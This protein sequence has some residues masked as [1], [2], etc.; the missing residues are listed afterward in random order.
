ML[1]FIDKYFSSRAV[2]E[3]H[4]RHDGGS[5]E[6]GFYGYIRVKNNWRQEQEKREWREWREMNNMMFEPKVFVRREMNNMMFEPKVFV[7]HIRNTLC[8]RLDQKDETRMLSKVEN[9]SDLNN[10]HVET[11]SV[12]QTHAFVCISDA[13]CISDENLDIVIRWLTEADERLRNERKEFLKKFHVLILLIRLVA[14]FGLDSVTVLNSKKKSRLKYRSEKIAVLILWSCG[15]IERNPGPVSDDLRDFCKKMISLLIIEYWECKG[16]K[17]GQADY[18]RRP[19]EWPK[20]DDKDNKVW[21]GDPSKCKNKQDRDAMLNCL[22]D[23]CLRKGVKVPKEWLSLIDKY[24]KG[25]DKNC[26]KADKEQYARD[27]QTWV[28]RLRSSETV[29]QVFDRLSDVSEQDRNAILG[30]ILDRLRQHIPDL[31]SNIF[32]SQVVEETGVVSQHLEST[33]QIAETS[34]PVKS[35]SEKGEETEDNSYLGGKEFKPTLNPSSSDTN[36]QETVIHL[37]SYSSGMTSVTSP[38]NTNNVEQDSW[39]N[40]D[41]LSDNVSWSSINVP[42]FSLTDYC[43]Q[44]SYDVE[45]SRNSTNYLKRKCVAETGD[46][47]G[48]S[49]AKQPAVWIAQNTGNVEDVSRHNTQTLDDLMQLINTSEFGDCAVTETAG[50]TITNG[51]SR[52]DGFDYGFLQQ[53]CE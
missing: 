34:D 11:C 10:T 47:M 29:D 8:P 46:N 21:F 6:R 25:L 40:N 22:L 32:Q 20:D 45:D 5:N 44:N 39:L 52:L 13:V 24:R 42:D 37:T 49:A 23:I 33:R 9:L 30:H 16:G 48:P 15:D 17:L 35:P 27:L 53:L 36:V 3:V 4:L 31:H 18:K 43:L 41:I 26:C 14:W 38:E 2:E 7:S 12:L 28:Q 1:S 50:E 51:S 19:D